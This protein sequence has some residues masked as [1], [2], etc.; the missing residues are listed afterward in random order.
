MSASLDFQAIFGRKLFFLPSQF[1]GPWEYRIWPNV[2]IWKASNLSKLEQK[3]Y[4]IFFFKSRKQ[5]KWERKGSKKGLFTSDII[6]F[7]YGLKI[8]VKI[9]TNVALAWYWGF[10]YFPFWLLNFLVLTCWTRN[11]E[12]EY[13]NL[14]QARFARTWAD[15]NNMDL[16][17]AHIHQTGAQG[18]FHYYGTLAH[19]AH[20]SFMKP[21]QLPGEYTTQLQP[22]WHIIKHNN[23][24]CP[25]SV[26][27]S[28][29][30]GQKQLW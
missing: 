26:P 12:N 8:S 9:T 13:S 23:Q 28:L 6:C 25:H 18:T 22:S 27:I 10:R 11:K 24:L 14:C 30:G 4:R 16:Y 15:N 2:F 1:Q 19:Q 7:G 5:W 3:N 29:L 20:K 17:S 21:S